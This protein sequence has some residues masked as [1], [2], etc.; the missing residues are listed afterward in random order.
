MK[1]I[2]CL[3]SG[4]GKCGEA[5][6]DAMEQVG[7]LLATE[8]ATVITGGFGGSG[9]EAPAKGAQRMGG[10]TVGYTLIGLP[11]NPY[12]S[13]VVDCAKNGDS[14]EIQFGTRLGHLLSAN[15]FIVGAAGGAGT[16][17]ELMAIINLNA[18]FWKEKKKVVILK[19]GS[20]QCSGWDESMLQQLKS[21]G[22]LPD[23]VEVKVVDTPRAAVAAV[24]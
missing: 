18:K 19:P 12:F 7:V 4:S 16:L 14:P 23:S 17:V 21:W 5:M 15:G 10:K 8:G 20:L 11:A 1:T 6:Y 2:A 24:L 3:G 22:V 13:E 9:M